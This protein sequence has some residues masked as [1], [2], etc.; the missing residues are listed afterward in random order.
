VH[1]GADAKTSPKLDTPGKRAL[2]DNLLPKAPDKDGNV[3]QEAAPYGD[4]QEIAVNQA[5]QID[6]LVKKVR[7]AGWRGVKARE[8]IIKAALMELLSGN[9]D[10]VERVFTIL[11][12]QKEY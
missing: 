1:T 8:N 6:A 7:P 4:A 5:L 3:V 11:V 9:K 12:A 10:T 2:Y